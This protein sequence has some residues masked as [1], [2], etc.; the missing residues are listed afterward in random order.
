[1]RRT[2]K[3]SRTPQRTIAARRKR[4]FSGGDEGV[5][6]TKGGTEQRLTLSENNVIYM[7]ENASSGARNNALGCTRHCNSVAGV[8]VEMRE[9]CRRTA[10]QNRTRNF[11]ETGLHIHIKMRAA[12]RAKTLRGRSGT[13][14]SFVG[15]SQRAR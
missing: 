13:C 7:H 3:T 12:G 5:V 9:W 1:M 10:H 6:Q 4:N 14:A 11:L 2:K 15:R 8:L